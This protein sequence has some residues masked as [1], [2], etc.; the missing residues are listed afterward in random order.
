ME[1]RFGPIGNDRYRDYLKD[2][3]A[4]GQHVMSLVNDLLDLAKIEAGKLELDFAP[5]DANQVIQRL[6]LADAAAGLARAHHR[7]H[8]AHRPAAAT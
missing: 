5:V 1:E 7:A 8:V 2:I 4:S 3:H 6:R